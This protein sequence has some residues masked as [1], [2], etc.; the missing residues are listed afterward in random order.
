MLNFIEFLKKRPSDKNMRI[1]R[2]IFGLII[3]FLLGIYFK[4]YTINLPSSL[5]SS[6]LYIKYSL[7]ILGIVPILMGAFD[8]CF[9]KRKYVKIIQIVF[10]LTLIIVGNNINVGEIK[11][12]VLK[13]VA[14]SGSIN[15]ADITS[16]TN[17][18]SPINI[19]FWIALLGIMPLIAG[20]S[21]KCISK[22]CYKHGETITK[23]RV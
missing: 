14:Q 19:G 20:I 9:A 15:L 5:K 16:S 3:I 10:G 7:F 23:I 4:S 12:E 22:K 8:P 21:G 1:A 2:I 17:K 18:S 13:P 6:E 11:K